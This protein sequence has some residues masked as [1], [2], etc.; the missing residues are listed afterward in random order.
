MGGPLARSGAG[1]EMQNWFMPPQEG[2]E[3][4]SVPGTHDAESTCTKP[5]QLPHCTLITVA[6]DLAGGGAAGLGGGMGGGT[7]KIGAGGGGAAGL[8]DRPLRRHHQQTKDTKQMLQRTTIT[9]TASTRG[10]VF[11]VG[12]SSSSSSSG[13]SFA[14]KRSPG[15]SV[16]SGVHTQVPSLHGGEAQSSQA[17]PQHVKELLWASQSPPPKAPDLPEHLPAAPAAHATTNNAR[18]W[19]DDARGFAAARAGASMAPQVA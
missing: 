16:G 5:L 1:A 19:R 3:N 8:R 15:G 4:C 18:T 10:F 13:K 2:Q 7:G 9:V 12:S 17:R 11:D 14:L 6:G